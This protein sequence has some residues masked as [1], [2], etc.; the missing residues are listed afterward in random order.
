MSN[1]DGKQAAFL[2]RFH[3]RFDR[4]RE[5]AI[6][7]RRHGVFHQIGASLVRFLELERIQRRLVMIAP[8]DVV[9]AA[10][11][12]DQQLVHIGSGTPDKRIGGPRITFL[13]ASHPHTSTARTPDVSGSGREVHE[14]AVGPVIVVA[15]DQ[16]LFIGEH[17]APAR[18]ALLGL[19]DPGGGL[20]D[21]IGGETG[22]RRGFVEAGFVRSLGEVLG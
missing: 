11:A 18:A 3:D 7:H 14:R 13:M 10:F 22:D 16:A 1:I 9:D 12:L 15:P 5:V 2:Y 6:G 19:S 20:R 8:P 4:L 17:R 21:L